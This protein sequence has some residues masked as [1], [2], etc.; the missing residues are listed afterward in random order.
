M[1]DLPKHKG[2]RKQLV[3]LLK[4]KGISDS[5]VLDAIGKVPR[6]FF[7]DTAFLPFAYQDNAFPIGAGQTIS[8]PFTVAFQSQLLEV[9]K[10]EKVLEI[11]TGSGYQTTIL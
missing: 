3:Q 6:H 11:G 8:Q 5:S 2:L 7:F 1:E 9:K 4:D 10:G